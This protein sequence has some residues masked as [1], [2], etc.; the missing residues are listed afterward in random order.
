MGMS[1]VTDTADIGS[2]ISIQ[3]HV[4][5]FTA[6]MSDV[7]HFLR[8]FAMDCLRCFR[9]LFV[10]SMKCYDKCL[11]SYDIFGMIFYVI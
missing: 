7:A 8:V 3:A 10:V 6:T 11:L 2:A 5:R 9:F 1:T 4:C